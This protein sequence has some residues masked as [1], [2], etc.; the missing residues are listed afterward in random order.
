[1]KWQKFFHFLKR[2]NPCEREGER[3]GGGEGDY[4]HGR[5]G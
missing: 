1:M 3:G 5:F 4:K 2:V